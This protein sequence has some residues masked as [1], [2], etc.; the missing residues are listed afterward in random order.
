[1]QE[2]NTAA[3]CVREVFPDAEIIS[4]RTNKYPIRVIVSTN[5]DGKE[6]ELWSGRQQNLF[7]KYRSERTRAMNEIKSNLQALK[8][9]M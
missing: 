8:S 7:S 1:M 6:T 2:F 4:N 5:L 3:S 9:K